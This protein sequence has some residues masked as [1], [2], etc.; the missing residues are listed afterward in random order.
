MELVMKLVIVSE[1]GG[2]LRYISNSTQMLTGFML[3]E[4][5][6]GRPEQRAQ[7]WKFM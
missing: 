1:L 6:R 7:L 3:L 2:R 5:R 4:F